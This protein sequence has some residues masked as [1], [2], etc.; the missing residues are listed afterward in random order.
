M[1]RISP[2][3]MTFFSYHITTLQSKVAE[4]DQRLHLLESLVG[5]VSGDMQ[6]VVD[7]NVVSAHS[8]IGNTPPPLFLLLLLF[9]YFFIVTMWSEPFAKMLQSTMREGL[10]RKIEIKSEELDSV[11]AV[12]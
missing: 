7:D 9:S 6:F 10:T 11:K 8:E 12:C 3:S 4:A 5:G 2:I 1:T